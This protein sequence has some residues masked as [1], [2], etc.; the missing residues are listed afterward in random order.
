MGKTDAST[1]QSVN[2]TEID[3][4]PDVE[5]QT[6]PKQQQDQYATPG[7]PA[8]RR[9]VVAPVLAGK[10]SIFSAFMVT[11]LSSEMKPPLPL[12]DGPA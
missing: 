10:A 5:S 8:S 12:P 1:R 3:A 7:K 9:S 2:P 11:L 6:A 4:P